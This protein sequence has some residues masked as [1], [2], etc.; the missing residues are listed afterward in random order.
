[1]DWKKRNGIRR[2]GGVQ[3]DRAITI[4]YWGLAR[5]SA[6]AQ[7]ELAAFRLV[8]PINPIQLLKRSDGI[9]KVMGS[10]SEVPVR[11][12]VLLPSAKKQA[13]VPRRTWIRVRFPHVT[14]C[15]PPLRSAT[16]C[17]FAGTLTY[18]R[19]C[20][21]KAFD[22]LDGNKRAATNLFFNKYALLDEFVDRG[23]T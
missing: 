23:P 4:G 19:F 3:L 18:G 11:G 16:S 14:V 12:P 10:N 22:A 1:M 5:L 21:G 8:A 13:A 15:R 7:E 20:T 2:H 6:I 9:S 17:F